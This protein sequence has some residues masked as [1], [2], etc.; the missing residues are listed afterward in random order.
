MYGSAVRLAALALGL[1]ALWSA[2]A[3]TVR[4]DLMP[5]PRSALGSGSGALV[6]APDSG[7]ASNAY[8]AHDAEHGVTAADLAKRGRITG[9][10]L[11]YVVPDAIV[12]QARQE[13]LGV[14]T[15][16]ELYRGPAAATGALAFWRRVTRELA[17][18][19]ANAVTV[20]VATFPT[21]ID[22]GSF[23]FEV[24]YRQAGEPLYRVGDV[25]FRTGRLLGSVFVTA[26][27]E[28]GL[29]ERTVQLADRLA[30]R[31]RRVLDGQIK[32]SAVPLPSRDGHG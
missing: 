6:L 14:R 3:S 21:R 32:A 26:T 15:I 8:A 20:S 10:V 4:L 22:D 17:G 28:A 9:Y 19:H 5:L 11:D 27:E 7:V 31:I 25:V 13:L 12:P 23:G 18:P 29:R 16:A 24:T 30:S 1:G 2:T